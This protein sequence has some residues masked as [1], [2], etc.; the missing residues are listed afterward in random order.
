VE[1]RSG[2][3]SRRGPNRRTSGVSRSS[4]ISVKRGRRRGWG[5]GG[6]SDEDGVSSEGDFNST[7]PNRPGVPTEGVA[8][9]DGSSIVNS[10]GRSCRARWGTAGASGSALLAK[11]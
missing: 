1:P 8:G 5:G 3:A 11:M 10:R 4:W 7:A 9:G 2:S 6:E